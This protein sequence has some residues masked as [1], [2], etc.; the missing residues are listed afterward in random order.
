MISD[1]TGENAARVR[2]SIAGKIAELEAEYNAQAAVALPSL[3]GDTH[4]VL[5]RYRLAQ[6]DLA[7]KE[8]R[9]AWLAAQVAS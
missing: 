3:P 9:R 6:A 5:V 4:E 8:A 1:A 7:A 2:T